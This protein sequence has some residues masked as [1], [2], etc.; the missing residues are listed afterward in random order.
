MSTIKIGGAVTLRDG[1]T[2]ETTQCVECGGFIFHPVVDNRV[3]IESNEA[4]Y[5]CDCC[6]ELYAIQLTPAEEAHLEEER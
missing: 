4:L 2:G 6:D 3:Q 5:A 1:K